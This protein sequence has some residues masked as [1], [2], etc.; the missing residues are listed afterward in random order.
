MM[1]K[2]DVSN[3]I[4][5]ATDRVLEILDGE[6]AQH[7]EFRSDLDNNFAVT[8]ATLVSALSLRMFRGASE[9]ADV[10]VSEEDRRALLIQISDRLLKL[11]NFLMQELVDNKCTALRKMI[12]LGYDAGDD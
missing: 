2:S 4:A 9:M 5:N 12:T 10:K 8:Q 3:A 11:T 7:E 6:L 1:D